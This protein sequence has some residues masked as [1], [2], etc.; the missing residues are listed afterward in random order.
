MFTFQSFRYMVELA[1]IAQM[2]KIDCVETW[3]TKIVQ[4]H[5]ILLLLSSRL[6]TTF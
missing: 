1:L 6:T 4:S 2:P 3:A 5:Y